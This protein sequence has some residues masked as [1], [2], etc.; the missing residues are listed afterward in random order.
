MIAGNTV[1]AT[2]IITGNLFTST[3]MIDD[4]KVTLL[5]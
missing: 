4:I 1:T 2:D 5:I 3:D